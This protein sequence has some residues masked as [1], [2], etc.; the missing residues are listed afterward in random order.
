M[1]VNI[2]AQVFEHNHWANQQI[3]QACLALTE[4]QLDGEPHSATRGSIRTTLLHLV[5]SQ[6]AYLQTLTLPVEARTKEEVMMST[7]LASETASSRGLIALAQRAAGP[8][9]EASVQTSNGN[10]VEPWVILLQAINHATEHREQIKSM[11]TAL[12][13]TPPEID[14]WDFGLAR[15]A[16]ILSD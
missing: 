13:V 3:I 1:A 12:G 5:L 14:G 6:D 9:I 4:E 11:L 8:D 15:G 10:S 7:A 16:F 2:I